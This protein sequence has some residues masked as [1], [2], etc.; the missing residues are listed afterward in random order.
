MGNSAGQTTLNYLFKADEEYK[1]IQVYITNE[2]I[3][4]INY[5]KPLPPITIEDLNNRTIFKERDSVKP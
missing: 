5:N 4:I 1:T 3:N 2:E